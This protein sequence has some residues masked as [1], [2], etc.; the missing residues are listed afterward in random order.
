M[1]T[2]LLLEDELALMK[3][4]SRV[5]ERRGYIVEQASTAKDALKQFRDANRRIDIL[6]ADVNLPESSGIQIAVLL[7]AA[8]PGPK[9]ILT[10][11]YPSNAW[12][13][14]EAADLQRLGADTVIVLH[15]PFMPQ[16]LLNCIRE[17]TDVP[18]SASAALSS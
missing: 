2:I 7:R 3:L 10:S 1:K 11:G 18:L 9:V 14:R 12:K 8:S 6:V 17:M 4:L 5:L 15:K 13:A 16:A